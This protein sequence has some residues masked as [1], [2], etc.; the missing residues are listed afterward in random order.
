M[1]ET[2]KNILLKAGP[3]LVNVCKND[4]QSVFFQSVTMVDTELLKYLLKILDQIADKSVLLQ[5][6]TSMKTIIH[7]ACWFGKLSHLEVLETYCRHHNLTIDWN[8][9]DAYGHTPLMKACSSGC[10][11]TFAV[12]EWLVGRL[13]KAALAATDKQGR[14]AMHHCAEQI[15][16]QE[17]I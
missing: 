10:L 12:V 1:T 14:S 6:D 4:G 2:A 5:A 13:P 16:E 9:A 8:Q 11:G 3:Q 7:V 15:S 17:K